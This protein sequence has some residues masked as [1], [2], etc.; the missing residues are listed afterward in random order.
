MMNHQT[1][2]QTFTPGDDQ[3]LTNNPEIFLNDIFTDCCCKYCLY[4]KVLEDAVPCA[5]LCSLCRCL[6][7]KFL[8]IM[9]CIQ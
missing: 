6:C 5:L 7:S 1:R 2:A 8:C 3:N 9:W 4:M